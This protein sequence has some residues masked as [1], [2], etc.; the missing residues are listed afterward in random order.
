[1][2]EKKYYDVVVIGAGP[3][4]YVAAIKASQAGKK[5]ALIEKGDLGGTCLNVGCIPTKTLIANAHVL[6][7]IQHATDFGIQ[8]GSIHFDF[9]KMKERKDNVVAKIRKSLEGLIQS[10]GIEILRG[11]ASFTAPFELKIKGENNGMIHGEKIIIASGSEPIDVGAFP[12][13]HVKIF[14]S[15][16]ILGLTTL[17]KTIAVIGG[18]YIGC[19]F[20]SLFAELG[21]KVTVLEALPS[22]VATQGK[23]ISDALTV[24][25]KKKGIDIR[26]GVMVEG[27]DRQGNGVTMCLKDQPSVSADIV[28]VAIGRKVVSKELGL[29]AAGVVTTEKGAITVNEKM[30]TNVPGI[31]QCRWE[32][33]LQEHARAGPPRIEESLEDPGRDQSDRARC[34]AGRRR[35]HRTFRPCAVAPRPQVGLHPHGGSQLR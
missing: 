14:N 20:A 33:G 1:M 16:S 25:F 29:Q 24:A 30:E 32:H 8:V 35:P 2:T 23:A 10:N 3:G 22:L 28:L 34:P 21:V 13:D 5:V 11:E 19:E 15:T 7:T 31:A 27:I 9:A 18:G 12:C 26:T 4:G 17:P 6:K